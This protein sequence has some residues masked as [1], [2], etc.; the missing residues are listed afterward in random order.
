MN[1]ET[2]ASSNNIWIKKLIEDHF[3][4]FFSE[5]QLNKYKHQKLPNV[6]GIFYENVINQIRL[7]LKIL[8]IL[9]F[10]L[11]PRVQLLQRFE[12][13]QTILDSDTPTSTLLEL[14]KQKFQTVHVGKGEKNKV[15]DMKAFLIDLLD[16]CVLSDQSSALKKILLW[17]RDDIAGNAKFSPIFLYTWHEDD[18]FI[19]NN[20]AYIHACQ[21]NDFQMVSHFMGISFGKN[22]VGFRPVEVLRVT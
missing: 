22:N 9:T 10:R 14:I 12:Y 4:D 5:S 13:F 21:K 11:T 2:F 20:R 16:C 1:R 18:G 15:E 6:N 17:I 8:L 19:W 7:G 3:E